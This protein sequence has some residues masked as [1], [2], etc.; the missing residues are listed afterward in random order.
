MSRRSFT[1]SLFILQ[2][3]EAKGERSE[4]G[5]SHPTCVFGLKWRKESPE[6]S[7]IWNNLNRMRVISV[8]PSHNFWLA[9]LT[10]LFS[11]FSLMIISF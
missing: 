4:R 6:G 11:Y 8:L 10:S 7:V 1:N 5:K 2:T 9:E 3:R